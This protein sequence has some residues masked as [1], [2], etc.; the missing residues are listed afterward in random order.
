MIATSSLRS[1]L[2]GGGI[3]CGLA[4]TLSAQADHFNAELLPT[5]RRAASVVPGAAP[6]SVRYVV[7]NPGIAPLSAFVDGGGQN[8]VP[9]GFTVFQIRFPEGW[10][11]VD[12]ALDR[13]F[14]PNSKSFDDDTY[15]NIH[16]ALRGARLSVITHEH[17]DHVAGVL[18]SP[19]LEQVRAHTLLTRTQVQSLI[20]RPNDPRI[21]IDS[22]VGARYL[23]IDYDP[24]LPIAPGVV[25]IKAPGHTVGSQIVYVR[26]VS[27]AEIIIAGDVA[28][29]MRG[30]DSLAQKPDAG[31]RGF[32]GEDKESIAKE[33]R[34]LRNAA[35]P[36]TT[37]LVSHDLN[38]LDTLVA[39]GRLK[40]GFDLTK[41]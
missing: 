37:V 8:T 13:T 10:I 5:I 40:V 32:G 21:K 9:V 18:S 3:I 14:V 6:T 17:H 28:W 26:L 38:R 16:E 1:I 36:H 35:G 33:L 11:T 7:L 29:S 41:P 2:V 23:V 34:W 15:R 19:A 12:A 4:A 31:T 27:G 24:I 25:L 22:T 39:Q 20:A 30:I